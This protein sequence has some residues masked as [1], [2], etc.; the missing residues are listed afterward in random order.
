M[1]SIVM[2]ANAFGSDGF[3]VNG[4]V[5][6]VGSA[7]KTELPC[8]AEPIVVGRRLSNGSGCEGCAERSKTTGDLSVH[9]FPSLVQLGRLTWDNT[10]EQSHRMHY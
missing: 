2:S 8:L 5:D 9:V 4:V 10:T 1:G 6:Y 7:G 3:L